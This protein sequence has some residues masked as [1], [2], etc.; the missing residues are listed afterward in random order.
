M[1]EYESLVQKYQNMKKEHADAEEILD[2]LNEIS[3]Y[4]NDERLM[5]EQ[6]LWYW[7]AGYPARAKRVCKQLINYFH[8]GDW[9]DRA[10]YVLEKL[11]DD[12]DFPDDQIK[13]LEPD[14]AEEKDNEKRPEKSGPKTD[15]NAAEKKPAAKVQHL[16]ISEHFE[17]KGA[18]TA[19]E[20]NEDYQLPPVIAEAFDGL[21][22]MEIV[23]KQLIS[24]YNIAKLEKLREDQLGIEKNTSRGYNFVLYGNPGTG[25][26]TVARIIGKVLYALGIRESDA[27]MEVD[28]SGLVSQYIGETAARVQ[29]I[30]EEIT[31]GT[32]FIDEA[33]SLFKKGDE[34]DFGKEAIDTLLKHMED[35]RS[36]Y[37]VIIAGYKDKMT[38]MLNYAN[39]GFRSRFTYH[40]HIPDYTDDELIQIAENIAKDHH[41]T[42][43]AQGYDALRKRIDIERIDETFGNARFIRGVIDEAEANLA[44]RLAFMKSFNRNDLVTLRAIDICPERGDKETLEELL[45]KMDS[46]IGLHDVKVSVQEMIDKIAVSREMERRGL[47]GNYDF[48]SLHMSFKGNAGTGKTTVA[49]LLGKILGEM[50]VLKRGDVFVEVTR[51][52]LVGQYQGT[53]AAKVKDV[54]RS[55]MGGIL[56]IDEAYSLITGDKDDYGHEAVD[57]LVAEMENHRDSLMVILAGYSSDIDH[58]LTENQGLRSRVTRDMFFEDYTLDEMV[59][60]FRLN[61]KS[62]GLQMDESLY[63]VVKERLEKEMEASSNFGNGRGVRN[64]FEAI[65]RAKDSRIADCL[66]TGQAIEDRDFVMILEEDLQ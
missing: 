49:R 29:G 34:K 4:S 10:K 17:E 39:P 13:Y 7:K 8:D 57:T 53:T 9:V 16:Q 63:P 14:A 20:Y 55:A 45:K 22:G 43:E 23:K 37:S 5:Y 54:I 52:D 41:Y 46:L 11:S 35:H 18:A 62:S 50:G 59:D 64:V 44:N 42:I 58:F 38:E 3:E 61:V 6:A 47:P 31:G 66:R 21:V 19:I 15:V 32:L 27:F 2:I 30:L 28:R 25:K 36:E 24:F 26:T 40:I 51:A 1:G 60:I 56:F 12:E 33:Y 65:V 48:G